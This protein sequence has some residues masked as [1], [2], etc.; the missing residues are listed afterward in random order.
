MTRPGHFRVPGGVISPNPVLAPWMSGGR[1]LAKVPLAPSRAG[2]MDDNE[3]RFE[4][5]GDEWPTMFA[6]DAA[7][8]GGPTDPLEAIEDEPDDDDEKPKKMA[9]STKVVLIAAVWVLFTL[10][11]VGRFSQDKPDAVSTQFGTSEGFDDG[12]TPD[13]IDTPEEEAADVNGD[14][15]LDDDELAAAVEG[16][17]SAREEASAGDAASAGD[18]GGAGGSSGGGYDGTPTDAPATPAV[19]G[20]P[21][22]GATTTTV[23]GGGTITK[24]TTTTTT[25]AGGGATTI[26]TSTTTTA[27]GGATTT[28]PGTAVPLVIFAYNDSGYSYLTGYEEPLTLYR[29]STITFDNRD[30]GTRHSFTV[31]G[32][33]DSGTIRANDD[34]ETSPALAPGTY[35]YSCLNHPDDMKGTLTVT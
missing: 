34:P 32:I 6:P 24:T 15:V 31:P 23:G 26:T 27:G 22:A 21:P 10:F 8:A 13:V 12:G 1:A 20:A 30:L 16:L 19:P 7:G 3:E 17:A 5:E 33:W 18:P 28:A 25:T 2:V 14:G 4:T 9:T 11:L 29:G 35:T